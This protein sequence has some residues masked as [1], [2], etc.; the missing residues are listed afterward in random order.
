[1]GDFF[2]VDTGQLRSHAEHVNGVAGQADTA[3]DAGH[4]ITPGG[5]DIAYGLI[6]QFFPPMLKPVEGRATDALQTTSDKLHNAVDNLNDTAQS[7]DTLD[8]N[9]TQ[10]IENILQEL[11]RITIIDTPATPC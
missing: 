6:C 1:M 7:Y 5:F 2:E 9:V 10:L 3:L 4:Q 11:N 8:R